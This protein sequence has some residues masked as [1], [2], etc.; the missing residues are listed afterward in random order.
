MAASKSLS[1]PLA[2]LTIS[3]A[4]YSFL[5]VASA[6]AL[7]GRKIPDYWE[8]I[9]NLTDPSVVRIANFAVAEQNKQPNATK[10]EFVSIIKG[11]RQVVAGF[12]YRLVIAATVG[13]SKSTE[14]NY[15][16]ATLYE[17]SEK[18]LELT[19]FKKYLKN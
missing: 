17:S 11:E 6:A 10:L 7:G 9:E 13:G 3:V 14:P 19:S 8:P 18:V 16:F 1:L 15:Y 2:I 12:L 4:I 5:A